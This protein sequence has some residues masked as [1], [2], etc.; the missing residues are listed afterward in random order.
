MFHFKLPR[1]HN[2][3]KHV[4]QFEV[5]LS[6]YDHFNIIHLSAL[7]YYYNS[8]VDYS[9]RYYDLHLAYI[10][11]LSSPAMPHTHVIFLHFIILT[12]FRR[13]IIFLIMQL[14]SASCCWLCIFGPNFIPS[15]LFRNILNNP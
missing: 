8:R 2:K 1:L 3:I 6:L 11:R 9:S 5:E 4:D 15:T 10:F 12:T 7:M 14:S 13:V